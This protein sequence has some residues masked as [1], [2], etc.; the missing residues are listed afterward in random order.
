MVPVPEIQEE[1]VLKGLLAGGILMG[2]SALFPEALVYP[3]LAA[4][5]GF[6]SGIYPGL[7]MA[8]PEGNHA[9]LEWAVALA[10]LALGLLG[11][12]M[13]PL[14]LVCAWALHGFWAG[15]HGVTALGGETPEGL[16]GFSFSLSVAIA[17]FVAYMW[18]VGG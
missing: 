6:A 12:W 1:I 10:V 14:L 2:V 7:A 9:G 16:P 8:G 11:L 13:S 5:L 18:A 4:V 3:L 15:V 17:A